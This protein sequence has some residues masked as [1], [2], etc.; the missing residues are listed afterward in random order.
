MPFQAKTDVQEVD[1]FISYH[2]DVPF[3]NY[4]N[5]EFTRLGAARRHVRRHIESGEIAR[6]LDDQ[7]HQNYHGL[8][9]DYRTV[10][11]GS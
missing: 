7:P 3:C 10:D 8:S 6:N 4:C 1:K 2:D 11:S 9:N 5:H